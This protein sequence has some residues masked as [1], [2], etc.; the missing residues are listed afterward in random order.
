LQMGLKGLN[1][2]KARVSLMLDLMG[3]G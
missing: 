2:Y 3:Q 1:A